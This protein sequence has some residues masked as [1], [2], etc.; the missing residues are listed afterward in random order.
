MEL[1]EPEDDTSVSYYTKFKTIALQHP[2]IVV[3]CIIV[4][5]LII[6]VCWLPQS[7]FS[8]TKKQC[9]QGLDKEIERL[10]QSIKKKQKPL[11]GY[12][13]DE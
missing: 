1:N 3:T 11:K 6:C 12:D 2:Y 4:L 13:P 10:I 8:R 7:P 9:G 5:I